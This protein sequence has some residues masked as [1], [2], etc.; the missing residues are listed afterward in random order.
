MSQMAPCITDHFDIVLFSLMFV[1]AY[2]HMSITWQQYLAHVNYHG[3]NMR[4]VSRKLKMWF[5]WKQKH[6]KAFCECVSLV[7]IWQSPLVAYKYKGLINGSYF[8]TFLHSISK[9]TFD[10]LQ[11]VF[12]V[13]LDK[14]VRSKS[15][16]ANLWTL[17]NLVWS[18]FF[19]NFMKYFS[20]HSFTK[21]ICYLVG[22]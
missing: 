19:F 2:S 8:S 17:K 7:G 3:N 14:Y 16:N 15:R 9:Q 18:K 13:L 12:V 20:Y 5:E 21:C 11:G 10:L 6:Q 22:R 4:R 1:A